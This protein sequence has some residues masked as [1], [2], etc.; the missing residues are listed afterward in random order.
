M[1]GDGNPEYAMRRLGDE[2]AR[3][4]TQRGFARSRLVILIFQEL[5]SADP[6]ADSISEGWLK[7][8][9]SGRMVRVDR[10]TIEAIA[11]ALRCSPAERAKLLLHADRS[12][13]GSAEPDAVAEALTYAMGHVY[14]ETHTILA[15]IIGQRRA[16]ELTQAELMEL[17][18][19]AA[20]L[21]SR[22]NQQQ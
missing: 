19:T 20:Q 3:L 16:A 4:R 12:P 7:R 1:A 8:L 17:V 2:V 10:S 5:T 21:I 6:I 18:L 11:R 22:Q 13:L 15:T 9:E 14:R